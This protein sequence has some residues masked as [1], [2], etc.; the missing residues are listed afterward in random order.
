MEQKNLRPPADCELSAGQ[1]DF[2]FH[3]PSELTTDSDASGKL[4]ELLGKTN[5]F[6]VGF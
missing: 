5:G 2:I 6:Y 1:H 4:L 3:G